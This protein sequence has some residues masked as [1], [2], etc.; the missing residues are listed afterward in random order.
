MIVTRLLLCLAA[1]LIAFAPAA[2]ATQPKPL[3]LSVPTFDLDLTPKPTQFL[4]RSVVRVPKRTGKYTLVRTHYDPTHQEA[5]VATEWR[6]DGAP[7]DLVLTVYAYPRGRGEEAELVQREIALVATAVQIGDTRGLSSD[8]HSGARQPF[9]VLRGAP[10]AVLEDKAPP[11]P[12][13]PTPKPEIRPVPAANADWVE[14]LEAENWRPPN[15]H[16]IRQAFSMKL[17]GVPMR[18]LAYVFHRHLFGFKVR[19]SV[20]EENM[21]QAAFEKAADAAARWLVPQID[22]QNIGTCGKVTVYHEPPGVDF[23]EWARGEIARGYARVQW[24]NC[25]LEENRKAGR[26]D[27]E[28]IEIA[29]PPG[30]WGKP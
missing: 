25:G 20:P 28:R 5:G 30:A 7:K 6:V 3:D 9:V 15:S 16:G 21:D 17:G 22:V 1:S 24:E 27:F 14:K 19:I 8:S 4:E 12:F 26:S 10:T 29:Y 11:A 23:E 18:S 13:D 2:A